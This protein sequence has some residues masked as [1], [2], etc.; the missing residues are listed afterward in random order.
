MR[1]QA[2]AKRQTS[3]VRHARN[4][5]RSVSG[6]D[7]CGGGAFMNEKWPAVV[8]KNA[9]SQDFLRRTACRA[10]AQHTASARAIRG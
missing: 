4:A 9:F 5:S 10:N 1:C 8:T 3:D 7:V 2:V 6:S